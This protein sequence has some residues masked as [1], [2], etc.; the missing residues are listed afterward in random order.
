MKK[1]NLKN[2]PFAKLETY[3]ETG[4]IYKTKKIKYWL[5]YNENPQIITFSIEE[6]MGGGGIQLN[7]SLKDLLQEINRGAKKYGA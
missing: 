4:R 7:V 6:D 3:D 2:S 5:C 1:K